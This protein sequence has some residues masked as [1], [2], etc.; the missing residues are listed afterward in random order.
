MSQLTVLCPLRH[1][2]HVDQRETDVGLFID[3]LIALKT[4]DRRDETFDLNIIEF[5][6]PP[7][8]YSTFFLF[9]YIYTLCIL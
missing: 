8:N 1:F 4:A 9:L 5:S 6:F 7:P 2:S 3:L